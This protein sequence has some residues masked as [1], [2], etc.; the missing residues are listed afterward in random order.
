METG[1]KDD[2]RVWE[3]WALGSKVRDYNIPAMPVSCASI[4]YASSL[5][6]EFTA[7]RA[8]LGSYIISLFSRRP[9]ASREPTPPLYRTYSI[10]DIYAAP[11]FQKRNPHYSLAARN[12]P[13]VCA[14]ICTRSFFQEKATCVCTPPPIYSSYFRVLHSNCYTYIEAIFRS[15]SY[16]YTLR[17]RNRAT[18]RLQGR[19]HT[20]IHVH[21]KFFSLNRRVYVYVYTIL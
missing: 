15:K 20:H 9:R 2:P 3:S 4:R 1:F 21:V 5:F 12:A 6:E 10:Y 8:L 11:P 7:A 18:C 19:K 14:L 17:I 16:I 13:S